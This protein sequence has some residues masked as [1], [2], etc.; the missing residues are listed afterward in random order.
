ML[1]RIAF[2]GLALPSLLLAAACSQSPQS[3]VSPSLAAGGDAAANPD[4]STLKVSAPVLVSPENGG[5]TDGVR[6]TVTFRN[7]SGRFTSVALGYRVQVFDAANALIADLTVPQD[8][9]GQTSLS[10]DG[11]LGNDTEY[12]WRV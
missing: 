5:V 2:R 3:P 6:P 1:R 8:P 10:A 11:D 12:R 9:S 7:S 4:G